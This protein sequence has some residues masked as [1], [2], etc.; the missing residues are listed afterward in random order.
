MGRRRCGSVPTVLPVRG[1]PQIPR[2]LRPMQR[3]PL[4]LRCRSCCTVDLVP[5]QPSCTVP[6]RMGAICCAQK[7][8]GASAQ[9]LLHDDT[10]DN[11][12]RI[13]RAPSI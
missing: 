1:V 13:S 4:A 5:A 7:I 6:V 12:E 8:Y 2:T 11:R 3:A 10:L 9:E